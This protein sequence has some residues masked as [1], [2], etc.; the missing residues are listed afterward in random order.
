MRPREP[1]SRIGTDRYVTEIIFRMYCC[2]RSICTCSTGMRVD[3]VRL[4][5]VDNEEYVDDD[6]EP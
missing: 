6:N 2:T 1:G 5:D 4:F 3:T